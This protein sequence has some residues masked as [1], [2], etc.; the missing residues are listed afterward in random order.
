[1]RSER[2]DFNWCWFW[3]SLV[4]TLMLMLYFPLFPHFFSDWLWP[5]W[6]QVIIL[7]TLNWM[8]KERMHRSRQPLAILSSLRIM[9]YKKCNRWQQRMYKGAFWFFSVCL[10]FRIHNLKLFRLWMI[11]NLFMWSM[12]VLMWVSWKSSNDEISNN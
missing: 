10:I 7:C 5:Y 2:G 9:L 12:W 1:M 11:M 4:Y 8:G 3:A 6:D